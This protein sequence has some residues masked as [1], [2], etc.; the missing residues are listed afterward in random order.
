M[1]TKD[2]A[3]LSVLGLATENLEKL[4]KEEIFKNLS[5]AKELGDVLKSYEKDLRDIAFSAAELVGERDDKGSMFVRLPDGSWFKK[6]ARTSVKVKTD[7]ALALF[8]E[9]GLDNRLT[10]DISALDPND[11][12]DYLPPHL[13]ADTTFT[14]KDEDVEQ[15]YYAGE[16]SDE[17]LQDLVERSVTYALK[18]SKKK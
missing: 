3:I 2:T 9:R 12:V 15:A 14:V 5:R 7:E 8:K 18:L 4:S 13:M 1:S 16:I 10:Y 17:E 11:I 6:E